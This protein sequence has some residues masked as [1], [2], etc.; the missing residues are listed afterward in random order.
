MGIWSGG[1]LFGQH[2]GEFSKW[3]NKLT[4]LHTNDTHSRIDPFPMDGSKYQGLGGV[5]RREVLINKIR[6]EE[7]HVLLVDAGDFF[8]GTPYFNVFGGELELKLMDQLGYD[9]VVAGNHDFD[10][11]E[12]HLADRMREA[13]LKMVI[14]NYDLQNSALK[15]L[16][17][18]YLVI[19]K[20]LI[21]IGILGAGIDLHGYLSPKLYEG[22]KF[23]DSVE[24]INYYA[25]FLKEERKCDLVICLSHLG[26]TYADS[27]QLSDLVLAAQTRD[28]DVIIGGHTHTFLEEPAKVKN[29][30]GR[31]VLVNQVG[32]GGI[33]LGRID[34]YFD[35]GG[36]RSMMGAREGKNVVVG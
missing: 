31:I 3:N 11:G 28:V 30:E 5:S 7:E 6:S 33:M 1:I 23:E 34:V 32:W 14:T 21:R 18:R 29:K 24:V 9:A 26:Y 22:I 25:R 8:Q 12:A 19:E 27:K 2:P 13:R 16:V 4:I 20:G 35:R 15:G 36:R 10:N 17:K